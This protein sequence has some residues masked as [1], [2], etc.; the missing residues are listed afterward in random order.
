LQLLLPKAASGAAHRRSDGPTVRRSDGPIERVSWRLVV[1]SSDSSVFSAWCDGCAG[2]GEWVGSWVAGRESWVAGRGSR[3][4]GCCDPFVCVC[5]LACA[6]VLL[7]C[8]RVC[9]CV[10][11]CCVCWLMVMSVSSSG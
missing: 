5:V 9:T 1:S 7:L 6:C 10:M 3:V 2:N 11:R 4:D 8:V